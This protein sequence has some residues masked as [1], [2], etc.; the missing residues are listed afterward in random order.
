MRTEGN[1]RTEKQKWA[2]FLGIPFQM[3]ALLMMGYFLGD[4]LDERYSSRHPW[5]TIGCTLLALFLSL[6]Q[7]I[8]QVK[9]FDAKK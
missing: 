8:K 1:K 7:I 6:Y 5:W 9:S 2:L 4:F 3:V